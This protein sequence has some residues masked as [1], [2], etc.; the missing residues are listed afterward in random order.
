MKKSRVRAR[1]V[2]RVCMYEHAVLQNVNEMRAVLLRQAEGNVERHSVT[3]QI[4]AF[5]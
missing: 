2:R 3:N 1:V 5:G 4:K